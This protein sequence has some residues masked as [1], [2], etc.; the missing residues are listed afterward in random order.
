MVLWKSRYVWRV[1]VAVCCVTEVF[2]ATSLGEHDPDKG[3]GY[4]SAY[5]IRCRSTAFP[6]EEENPK[7][8]VFGS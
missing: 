4:N 7:R 6:T 1:K 3:S 8:L 2:H 5:C